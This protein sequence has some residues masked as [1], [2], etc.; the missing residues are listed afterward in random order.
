[1]S[2]ALTH[3]FSNAQL[4]AIIEQAVVYLCACPAQ[5]AQ[6]LQ[7]LRALYAY[8]QNCLSQN[9]LSEEVHLKIA[10]ATS[11]VHDE[12][13]ECLYQI[14]LMEQWDMTTMTMPPGLR[15]LRDEQIEQY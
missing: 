7:G 2:A 1:M 15:K 5:V 10:E 11:R 14:L 4:Q 6:Q 13:E 8:Q 12:L 3:R 9:G